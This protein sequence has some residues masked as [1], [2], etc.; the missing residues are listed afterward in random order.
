MLLALL[1]P[2][3][4]LYHLQK[5]GRHRGTIFHVDKQVHFSL[6]TDLLDFYMFY[7]GNIKIYI[8]IWTKTDILKKKLEKN[9]TKFNSRNSTE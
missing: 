1:D 8:Y 4:F 9:K 6:F 5:V 3:L 7:C 2:G